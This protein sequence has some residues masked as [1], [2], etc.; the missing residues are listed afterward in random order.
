MNQIGFIG[1]ESFVDIFK[2]NAFLAKILNK[3]SNTISFY[4][5]GIETKCNNEIKK[6]A[7]V[8]NL[9]FKEFNPAYTGYRMYSYMPEEYYNDKNYHFS[10]LMHR[11]DLMLK[12]INYLFIFIDKDKS[13]DSFPYNYIFKK[14]KNDNKLFNNTIILNQ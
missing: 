1:D 5:D 7:L 10:Q 14:L 4:H 6:F 9:K 12:N 2:L 3:F 11:Y 8:N 13:L